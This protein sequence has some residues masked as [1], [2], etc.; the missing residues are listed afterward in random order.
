MSSLFFTVLSKIGI[1][2]LFIVV[3]YFISSLVDD[4]NRAS[5]T[6]AR[7]TKNF[8][9]PI[10]V[11]LSLA[12]NFTKENLSK[13][14]RYLV[15]GCIL[16]VLMAAL[17]T[18]LTFIFARKEKYRNVYWYIFTIANYGYFGYPL[19][20]QVFPSEIHGIMM[21][22]TIPLMVFN[23][24]IAVSVLSVDKSGKT[25]R[26]FKVPVAIIGVVLGIIVGLFAGPEFKEGLTLFKPISACFS[27]AA[28]LLLG[29]SLGSL[30]LSKIF[31]CK[32][33]YLISFIRLI[34]IPFIVGTI[35][36]FAG[37][38]GYELMIPI[39]ITAMPVGMNPIVFF[40]GEEKDRYIGAQHCIVS[41]LF[42]VITIP[43]IFHVLSFV[44]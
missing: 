15:I 24:T 30:P 34:I 20:E 6:F 19:I 1:M 18:V 10:Y 40:K 16:A 38:R 36:Y 9:L 21:I 35:A 43:L 12:E 25:K 29:L 44:M 13:S 7:V 31:K 8:L 5:K 11:F 26:K 4:K 37:L 33:S 14:T 23:Y 17:G 27:P 2:L 39:V 28:M 41:I 3:G 22:I 42:S 32:K